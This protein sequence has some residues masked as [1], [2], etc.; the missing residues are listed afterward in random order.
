MSRLDAIRRKLDE[1]YTPKVKYALLTS[2]LSGIAQGIVE[3]RKDGR[4]TALELR[5]ASLERER[6]ARHDVLRAV[7]TPPNPF[8]PNRKSPS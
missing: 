8:L 6:K 2:L 4:I 5:I 7:R 3:S 1:P